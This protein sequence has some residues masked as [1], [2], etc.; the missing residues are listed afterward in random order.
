MLPGANGSRGHGGA[1]G[2]APSPDGGL[3]RG[4]PGGQSG[5]DG[6][7]PAGQDGGAADGPRLDAPMTVD[8]AASRAWT[9]SACGTLAPTAPDQGALFDADGSIALIDEDGR[10]RTYDSSGTIRLGADGPAAFL[11][12][13]P[14]GVVLAGEATDTEIVLRPIGATAARFT[15]AIPPGANTCGPKRAFSVG[16]EYF[17]AYG[18]GSTCVWRSD[19]IDIDQMPVAVISGSIVQAAIRDDKVVVVGPPSDADSIEIVTLDFAGTEVSRAKVAVRPYSDPGF[20]LSPAGDRVVTTSGGMR[21]W[22]AGTGALILDLGDLFPST[23]P[24]FTPAGDAVLFG[25][26]VFRTADGA[27]VATLPPQS[28]VYDSRSA[29]LSADGRRLLVTPIGGRTALV[30]LSQPGFAAVL[31]PPPRSRTGVIGALA[32]SGDASTLTATYDGVVFGFRLAAPFEESRTLWTVWAGDLALEGDI[33]ADGQWVAAAGDNRALYG[34]ADGRLIWPEP[35]PLNVQC[36]GSELRISPRGKWAAGASYQKTMDVFSLAGAVGGTPWRPTAQLPTRC[37][38][39]A[40]F[41]R[42]EQTMATSAPA[43]YRTDANGAWQ[44]VWSRFTG[45]A[46]GEPPF[47]LS[48]AHLTPDE[49]AVLVSRCQSEP[50]ITR[51]HDLATGEVLRDL[52]ELTDPRPSLSP[53]GSWIVAGRTLLHLPSGDTRPLDPQRTIGTALFTS[54]GEI[55]AATSDG[56]LVRYCRTP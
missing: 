47:G 21:L 42:D 48:E 29:A 6:S 43:V 33:S 50:C 55:I 45:S 23:M 37:G 31:G 2:A 46:G 22:D 25:D 9:W 35:A 12:N 19:S 15:F 36:L 8:P 27:R 28:R 24:Q 14:D 34:A 52:P 38:D 49:T 18:G 56:T 1:G 32:I 11:I 30:D 3:M 10:I 13:G 26:G 20:L 40:T 5:G 54:H 53:D 44:Q 16:G 51:L 17:L 39:V 7:P 41:S 4:G